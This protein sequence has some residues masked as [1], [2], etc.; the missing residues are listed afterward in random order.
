MKVDV[1]I[2]GAGPAGG[3]S[4]LRLAKSGLK[5]A[6]LE[7]EKMPRPKACGGAISAATLERLQRWFSPTVASRAG[8]IR[9]CHNYA[10]PDIEAALDKPVILVDREHFDQE[11]IQAALHEGNGDVTLKDDWPVERIDEAGNGLT[12][13]GP[14]GEKIQAGFLIG[15]D[16]ANSRSARFLGLNHRSAA[17]M[18]IDALVRTNEKTMERFDST[19]RFNYFCIPSGYGWIFPKRDWLSCGM[20]SWC[21][22]YPTRRDM[23]D[24][25][26]RSLPAGSIRSVQ[27]RAHPVPLWTGFRRIATR[28][29]CLVGDAADMVHPITG[30]GIRFALDSGV[31]SAETILSLVTGPAGKTASQ[32]SVQ[33]DELGCRMYEK[34]IKQTIGQQFEIMQG[35]ALPVFLAAPDLFYRKFILEGRDLGTTYRNLAERIKTCG[36]E[37]V[38]GSVD[39]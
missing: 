8:K 2:I 20:G 4:A 28:R 25:L 26:E 15:A 16:G 18:A 3:M 14:R 33:A 30:E 17:G 23:H 9:L 10:K 34:R 29:A 31:L 32:R 36:V 27:M 24:F 13:C 35:L 19:V 7:K 22:P 5:V 39:G 1:I 37:P 38:P 6:V 21:K 12:V 11:L